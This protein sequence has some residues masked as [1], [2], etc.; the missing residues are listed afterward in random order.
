MEA[1]DDQDTCFYIHTLAVGSNRRLLLLQPQRVT[2][3]GQPGST[4]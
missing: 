2:I 1:T 3:S 4:G